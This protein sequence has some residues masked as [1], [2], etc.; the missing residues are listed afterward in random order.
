MLVALEWAVR[1][2]E[3]EWTTEREMAAL[4]T[5]LTHTHLLAYLRAHGATNVGSP[6]HIDRPWEK[7]STPK[8][9]TMGEFARGTLG[10]RQHG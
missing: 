7:K 2:R 8:M 9:M 3:T 1:T 4:T 10:G 5:E 6:L